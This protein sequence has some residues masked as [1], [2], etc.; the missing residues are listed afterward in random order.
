MA[1]N[2][3]HDLDD[4]ELYNRLDPSRLRGRLLD[5][6]QHCQAAWQQAQA[7]R[8]PDD[9]ADS[10]KV[11]IGGMGGSAIAG[12]LLADLAAVEGGVPILVVRDLRLPFRLNQRTL[13]F[14][15]SYSGNT[16]ETLALLDQAAQTEARIIAVSSGGTLT[17]WAKEHKVPLLTIDPSL[18]PRSAVG[19]NLLLLLGVLDQIGLV[20]LGLG[21]LDSTVQS[22]SK[23]ICQLKEDVV[24]AGNPAKQLAIELRDK[25][26]LVY[27]SGLFSGVARRWKSQFNENSKAWSYC[28]TIPEMLHN[29]VEAF[30]STLP[31]ADCAMVLLLQ[32][33]VWD[34]AHL[35]HYTV[36]AELLRR[37]NIPY[38]MLEGE[39][40]SPLGQLLDM[41]ILGD[42]TSYYLG[43]LQGVDPSPNP[44]I[45]AAKELLGNPPASPV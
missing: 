23:K 22:L 1:Q 10:D 39:Q 42:Y 21:E 26:I 9:W 20:H 14:A 40:G 8:L 15:C 27:G 44:S 45:D 37:E 30:R 33:N 6:P 38:R 17:A 3:E 4:G 29:S 43:L 24:I 41:L 31:M 5:L 11:V 13:F 32:P 36:V 34:S 19:Y 7:S 12:D 25:L 16:E 35:R 28:E 2:A 18:E